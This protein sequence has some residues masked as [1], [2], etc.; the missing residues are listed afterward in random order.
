LAP[1][2]PGGRA[3]KM[4]TFVDEVMRKMYNEVGIK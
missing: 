2:T 1:E 4:T 3:L